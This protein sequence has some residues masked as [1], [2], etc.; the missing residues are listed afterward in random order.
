MEQSDVR[1]NKAELHMRPFGR[2]CNYAPAQSRCERGQKSEI[3]SSSL[4]PELAAAFSGY[5][6][7]LKSPRLPRSRAAHF[8][9]RT[10][11]L[12]IRCAIEPSLVRPRP[13]D[14][15]C[16]KFIF[17]HRAFHPGHLNAIWTCQP[18]AAAN[19][20]G[21]KHI[22]NRSSRWANRTLG[23]SWSVAEAWVEH[24]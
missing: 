4:W 5:F 16:E 1:Q 18:G 6:S 7:R 20:R 19:G 22:G 10:L 15:Q 8:Q 9:L 24:S 11:G 17:L 13:N 12:I 2:P 14:K 3:C 23:E 21:K